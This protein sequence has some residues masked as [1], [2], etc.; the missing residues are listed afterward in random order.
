MKRI[1]LTLLL[2]V[3]TIASSA[4]E[5]FERGNQLYQ[6][7]QYA[8][9]AKSY[10]AELAKGVHSAGLYFNLANAYYKMDKVAPAVFYYE[11]ALLLEPND[12]DIRVNLG[13]AHKMMIDEVKELP[14][15][16]FARLLHDF[17]GLFHYDTWGWIA[18]GL[19]FLVLALFAGY[20][21]S[22]VALHKR[23]YFFSMLGAL[24]LVVCAAVSGIYEKERLASERPAIIF[25]PI[26]TIKGEPRPSSPDVITLHEGSKVYVLEELGEWKKV[27]LPDGN[28]G[29]IKS[30]AIREIKL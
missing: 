9:A 10:E 22:P 2:A 12:R 14:R 13:Y 18:V 20:Y 15:A 11:K 23:I 24:F 17:T 19:S 27:L 1:L 30:S 7:E 28:D 25:E 6:K 21:L 5:H 3:M 8:A 16:G 4:Q 29:W 26:I